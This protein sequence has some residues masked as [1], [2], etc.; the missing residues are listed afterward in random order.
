MVTLANGA[1][2]IAIG[3]IGYVPTTLFRP[4]ALKGSEKLLKFIHTL[5]Y[6][7]TRNKAE[8]CEK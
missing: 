7:P 1:M 4:M 2:V 5:L 3:A 6:R 8:E